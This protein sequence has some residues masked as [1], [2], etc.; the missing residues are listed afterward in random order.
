MK[1]NDRP[2]VVLTCAALASYYILEAIVVGELFLRGEGDKFSPVFLVKPVLFGYVLYRASR[3]GRRWVWLLG[4]LA[5]GALVR[6]LVIENGGVWA[7]YFFY[8]FAFLLAAAVWWLLKLREVDR[9]HAAEYGLESIAMVAL[10]VPI[11]RALETYGEVQSREPHDRVPDATWY[12]FAAG[13]HHEAKFVEWRGQIHVAAYRSEEPLPGPDLARVMTRYAD[14]QKW[15]ALTEG[16]LYQREDRTRRLWCSAM[17]MIGVGTSE[18]LDV[19]GR[20]RLEP[21]SGPESESRD[22]A[23]VS[24]PEEPDA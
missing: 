17:P 14:G 20:A 21:G 16:Y 24:F 23:R 15:I 13:P 8:S 9:A 4:L 7:P 2:Y 19:E 12:V 6:L 1:S 5:A 10:G 22:D 18:F 3:E 11:A